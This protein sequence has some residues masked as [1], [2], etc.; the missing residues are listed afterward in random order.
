M[1]P[2]AG[3][4]CNRRASS[5]ALGAGSR[6]RP[7]TRVARWATWPNTATSGTE[8]RVEL[9][10]ALVE[11][12]D[13]RV[14]DEPVLAV[15]LHRCGQRAQ[16]RVVAVGDRGSRDGQ[17]LHLVT[18]PAHEQL[19]TRADEPVGRVDEATRLL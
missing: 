13:D 4:G 18:D 17:G 6:N 15:V 3:L 11:G 9:D 5:S 12:F 7:L 16:R 19:G 14:D 8:P 2:T 10:A 1:P